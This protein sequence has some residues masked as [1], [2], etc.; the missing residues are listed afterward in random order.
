LGEVAARES[1]FKCQ[2]GDLP[3]LSEGQDI[4]DHKNRFGLLPYCRGKRRLSIRGGL[5]FKRLQRDA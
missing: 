3:S 5:N 1:I 4:R 2:R